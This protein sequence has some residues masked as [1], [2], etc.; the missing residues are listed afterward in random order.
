MFE[1]SRFSLPL[2][3][4]GLLA[5][6]FAVAPASAMV[7]VDDSFADGDLA[8][9]GALD[10]D[11]WTS[12]S[13]SGIEIAVGELGFVTGTS[14]R[15]IHTVFPTQTLANV[16][17][18]L[19]ATYT[20]T[21]PATVGSGSGSF[22]VGLFDTLGRAGLEANISASSSSPS[23]LYGNAANSVPG[24]PGYMLDMDVNNGA[25]DLNFRKHNVAS[26]T[27]RLMGT[28]GSGSFSSIS[29]SG[30]DNAYLLAPNTQYTGSF[31]IERINATEVELTATLDGATHSVTNTFD[32]VDIGM[33]AF[34][35]NSNQFGST[36]SRGEPDNGLDFS[37]VTVTFVPEPASLSLLAL[38][39]LAMLRRRA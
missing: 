36:N 20:F 17:D 37:N 23:D 3:G 21:T 24:L 15:G 2:L 39:G 34:H 19:T 32:S 30:P 14:G 12:S 38:G 10:T 16:G 7:V 31:S 8:Q 18:K 9:T 29:P 1:S 25:D 27:G 13:S 4:T 28:T 6:A 22:R 5:A 33:L 11:W 35:A 26:A